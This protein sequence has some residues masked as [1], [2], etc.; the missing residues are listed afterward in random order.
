M[1]VCPFSNITT[2]AKRTAGPIGINLVQHLGRVGYGF[3]NNRI[4]VAVFVL[5][6]FEFH[7]PN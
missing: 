3:Y 2:E 4:L 6:I 1:S 7:V 5:S